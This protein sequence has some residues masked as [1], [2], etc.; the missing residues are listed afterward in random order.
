MTHPELEPPVDLPLKRGAKGPGVRRVQEWLC[1]RGH[2]VAIDGDFGPATEA[3]LASFLER[4]SGG[5]VLNRDMWAELVSPMRIALMPPQ[6]QLGLTVR[7]TLAAHARAHAHLFQTAGAREVG[8]Q[9]RGPWV[10]LFMNGRD[11]EQWKWCAGFVSFCLRL[12]S[13]E[14]G[15]PLPFATS[16]SVDTIA[17]RAL[18]AGRWREGGKRHQPLEQDR[19][20][21]FLVRSSMSGLGQVQRSE[22]RPGSLLLPDYVHVGFVDDALADHFT[23]IEGNSN[24]AGSSNGDAVVRRHRGYKRCDFVAI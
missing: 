6:Q 20:W 1:L 10:R 13:E 23:T 5:G 4:R 2:P 24:D 8:G 21:L 11:G 22:E 12:A 14:T 7:D 19:G 16:F 18:A 17:S 9:N 3:A 15:Q